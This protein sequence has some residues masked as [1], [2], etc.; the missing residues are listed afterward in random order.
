MPAASS[1][2]QRGSLLVR[3]RLPQPGQQGDYA[4]RVVHGDVGGGPVRGARSARGQGGGWASQA[5]A[6]RWPSAAA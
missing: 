3:A 5:A 2:A 4:A 1:R 6:R